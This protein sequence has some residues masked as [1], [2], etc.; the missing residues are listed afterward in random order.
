[1]NTR[2]RAGS[3]LLILAVLVLSGLVILLIASLDELSFQPGRTFPRAGSSEEDSLDLQRTSPSLTQK[4]QICAYILGGLTLVSV[5]CVFI[6]RKLRKQFLQY[7]FMLFAFILPFVLILM[8]V[9]RMSSAWFQQHGGDIAASRPQ[10][11]E[12]LISNLPVWALAAA[13][14]TVAL[15]IIG[16]ILVF[17]DRWFAFLKFVRRTETERTDLPVEQQ[18]FADQAAVTAQRIRAGE[19]LQG[20]VI[21]CYRKMDQMLSKRRRLKP[22]YLTPREFASSLRELGIQSNHIQQLTELFELVRYGG[23]DDESMSQQA[24]ACLDQLQSAYGTR[25]THEI[26]T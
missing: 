1:M 6:L 18:T 5:I 25:E 9:S 2:P 11:P 14:V 24:L 16:V 17:A 12:S 21:R 20:E 26:T 22:T 15:L 10:V 19:S 23:R 8:L 13:A 4:E 3:A 7:M